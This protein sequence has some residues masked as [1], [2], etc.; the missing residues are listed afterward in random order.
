MLALDDRTFRAFADLMYKA[1]GLSFTPNK[2][3]LIASR[4][5]TR[6]QK[7]G[8]AGYGDYFSLLARDAARI[9]AAQHAGRAETVG[10]EAG[11]GLHQPRARHAIGVG[12]LQ[13]AAFA[14]C[15]H[16]GE[17]FRGHRVHPH[18]GRM[19]GELRY[20]VPVQEGRHLGL[21]RDV[22]ARHDEADAVD[23]HGSGPFDRGPQR[24]VHAKLTL[25]M[26]IRRQR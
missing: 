12:D 24:A 11:Q 25:T 21:D 1:A 20:R 2:K 15:V 23:T 18:P 17:L 10:P 9:I 3:P 6:V 22:R 7:L 4:L 14:L 19:E 26:I 5:G 8:L 16:R 13:H